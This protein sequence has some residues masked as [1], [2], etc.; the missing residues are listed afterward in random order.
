MTRVLLAVVGS[1]FDARLAEAADRLV[2]VDDRLD[3]VG[4][5]DDDVGVIGQREGNGVELHAA[6]M[7]PSR[8]RRARV[9]RHRQA[10]R[11]RPATDEPVQA[12]GPT[13]ITR[14]ISWSSWE[15]MWQCHT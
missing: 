6:S 9:D 7:H 12:P 3:E 4:L 13:C 5:P 1:D 14:I 8:P 15:R 2:Q 10:P 11:P